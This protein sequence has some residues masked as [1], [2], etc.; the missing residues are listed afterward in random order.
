MENIIHINSVEDYCAPI[1]IKIQNPLVTLVEFSKSFPVMSLKFRY[2]LYCIAFKEVNCGTLQYGRS[3]YDYQEGTMVFVAPGQMLSFNSDGK[4][5][6]PKGLVLLFHPDFIYGTPL[7][8]RMKDY[9]FF[10]YTSNE[11][12]HMSEEERE[13]ILGCFQN[14]RAELDKPVEEQSKQIVTS[15][16]ET[17]LDNCSNFYERQFTTRSKDSLDVLAKFE[18]L[19][20]EY[21]NSDKPKSQGLPSVQYFADEICLSPNYFGDLVKKE[22]GHSAQ[23]YIHIAIV[24]KA[25]ELLVENVLNVSEISYRL[26]FNYPHH[27]NRVFRKITG[28]TPSEY[29]RLSLNH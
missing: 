26:G 15:H 8:K 27:L 3:Q 24:E 6:T 21:Y 17:L 29:R 5:A 13:L 19:M 1:G 28:M 4:T 2:G 16:I 11:A 7:A 23:E 20:N 25:K 22:T 14:I 10:S 9:N 18:T 12:L